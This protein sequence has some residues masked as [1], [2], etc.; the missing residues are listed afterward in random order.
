MNLT[1]IMEREV[2][3]EEDKCRYAGRGGEC[4]RCNGYESEMECYEP[5]ETNKDNQNS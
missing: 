3:R 4:R 5:R 2:R 1:E